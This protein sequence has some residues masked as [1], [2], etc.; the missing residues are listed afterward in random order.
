MRIAI[1]GVGGVGGYFGARL[2]A[3]G[4]DV[5]FIARGAHLAAIRASG[6]RVESPLGDLHIHPAQATADPATIGPVD[7][8]LV[9]VKTWQL[10]AALES[11]R[12]LLGPD[13]AV[14]PLLNGVEAPATIADILGPQHALG[15]LCRIIAFLAGPGHIRHTGIEPAIV[16]GELDGRATP[17]SAAIHAAFTAAGIQSEIA[18]DITQ[19]LWEKFMLICTWSGLGAIT[20]APV[21][22]WR[23]LPGTRALA[24]QALREVVAVA[25]AHGVALADAQV[26]A[27]LR[28]L[29][30]V[31]PGGTA[32]MQRDIVEGRPSELE[33]QSGALVRLGVAAG[34]PTPVNSFIYHCLLPQEQA[35][36]GGVYQG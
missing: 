4:H 15:G 30:G 7:L 26:A 2:A 5:H 24:E 32:S 29:D 17:R 13:T 14:V 6:L 1:L 27:T 18:P 10:A 35:A 31:P 11:A 19:A 25:Q 23:S 20:R 22:V 8:V 21:G 9:G 28:F 12:P 3:A 16:F 33:A 36:R 34:V